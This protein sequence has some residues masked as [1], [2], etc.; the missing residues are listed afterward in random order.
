MRLKTSFFT[1]KKNKLS[2]KKKIR[3]DKADLLFL[4]LFFFVIVFTFE[5]RISCLSLRINLY[6]VNIKVD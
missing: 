6:P 4:F 1:I 3:F 5:E 2:L